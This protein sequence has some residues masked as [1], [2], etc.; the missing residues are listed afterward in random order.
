MDSPLHFV[1]PLTLAGF[2][3]TNV[4]QTYTNGCSHEKISTDSQTAGLSTL[5]IFISLKLFSSSHPLVRS[6]SLLYLSKQRTLPQ[7]SCTWML[8]GCT[9]LVHS[10]V[11]VL[12]ITPQRPSKKDFCSIYFIDSGVPLPT[13]SA[14]PDTHLP[15]T[16]APSASPLTISFPIMVAIRCQGKE[17]RG[18]PG[19]KK[20]QFGVRFEKMKSLK[21]ISVENEG[22][23][24]VLRD[25]LPRATTPQTPT[26]SKAKTVAVTFSM[27]CFGSRRKKKTQSKLIKSRNKL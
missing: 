20:T 25:R 8:E 15:P 21:G 11:V 19:S 10:G 14:S 4:K 2:L 7:Q 18:F 26:P 3:T 16:P 5:I 6:S 17:K 9:A 22:M 27:M 24:Y 1:D 12:I 13:P 23:S